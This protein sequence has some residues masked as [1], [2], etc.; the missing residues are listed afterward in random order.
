MKLFNLALF[1]AYKHNS[2][3]NWLTGTDPIGTSWHDAIPK[4]HPGGSSDMV[5]TIVVSKSLEQVLP[6]MAVKV[7]KGFLI[8]NLCAIVGVIC[9]RSKKRLNKQVQQSATSSTASTQKVDLLFHVSYLIKIFKLGFIQES[10]PKEGEYSNGQLCR[11][12]IRYHSVTDIGLIDVRPNIGLWGSD[13]EVRRWY[14]LRQCVTHNNLSDLD[15][16]EIVLAED[17]PGNIKA[18]LSNLL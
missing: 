13:E 1:S 18:Q 3:I 2:T 4:G 6:G 5:M 7:D 15:I 12:A 11:A 8:D 10:C 14:E 16:S 9:I 17:H